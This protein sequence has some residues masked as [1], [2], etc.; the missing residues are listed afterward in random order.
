M[1]HRAL[2]ISP[3][4]LDAEHHNAWRLSRFARWLTADGWE[5]RG[6]SASPS[7]Q[8]PQ[9]DSWTVRD[10]LGV[11]PGC[12]RSSAH[13]S[14][15][16]RGGLIR[17]RGLGR[18][19]IPD[20]GIAWSVAA[21]LSPTAHRLAR[22]ADVVISS[23]PPESPHL[24]AALLS[25]LHGKAHV[26]DMRDGWMDE[27]L[28]SELVTSSIRSW[29]ERHLEATVVRGAAGVVVTSPEWR[30]A[31]ASRYPQR[32]QKVAIVR[33]AMTTTG[34]AS[35]LHRN[36][37]HR[38]WVHAGRFGGS[39]ACRGPTPLINVLRHEAFSSPTPI[40]FRF[41]GSLEQHE[42]ELILALGA[43][44]RK[45]GC[46]VEVT[47]HVPRT[48]A[49]DEVNRADALLLLCASH[50]AIPSKLFE[51]AA[52]GKPILAICR[53]DGAT[54]N[55][56]SG[57]NCAM[58]VALDAQDVPAGFSKFADSRPV[59]D[60]ATELSEATARQDLLG[61]LNESVSRYG[62]DG[63]MNH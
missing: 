49:M 39:H 60:V 43:E 11:W 33:N 8:K 5:V 40:I 12:R 10:P 57:I 6:L 19:L 62:S 31:L 54:W 18:Q 17:G 53:P 20:A 37:P 45:T 27:P 16:P 38:V 25:R 61:L 48:I 59:P 1:A 63:L 4:S 2:L 32:A 15:R 50:H 21:C 9:I 14:P 46:T 55:A 51:Y 35:E 13:A 36:Q 23:S 47:G 26:M 30:V 7:A 3:F 34:A 22:W 56:C 42:V 24:A 44:V 28:R 58:R 29:I 52:T 41:V